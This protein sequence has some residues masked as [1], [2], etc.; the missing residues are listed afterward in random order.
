MLVEALR[1][2]VDDA[3]LA[4]GVFLEADHLGGRRQRVAGIDRLEKAAGGVAEIGDRVER[5]VGDR[6]AEHDVEGEQVVDRR[7]R[8]ADRAGEGLGAL[9]GEARPVE[10]R[11]KRDVAGRERARRRVAERLAEAEVLEEPAGG[12]LGRRAQG[13]VQKT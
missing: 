8:I 7:L 12:G 11:I 3:A 6:L 1:A 4:V 2:D 5:D 9:H 13:G 10:R